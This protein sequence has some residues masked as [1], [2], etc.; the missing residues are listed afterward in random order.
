[1]ATQTVLYNLE[2]GI[3]NTFICS[4]VGGEYAV[5][6]MGVTR[7]KNMA[8]YARYGVRY[9]APLLDLGVHKEE[10]RAL[11]RQH[12]VDPGWGRR[13]SHQGYQPICLLGFQHG[14]DILVDWHTTYPPQR[15]GDYLDEKAE[16]S[17]LLIKA[18]LRARG[19]D[20]ERLI[21][22]NLARYQAEEE[23]IAAVRARTA[24][25]ASPCDGPR[26]ALRGAGAPRP[27]FPF[28]TR[29]SPRTGG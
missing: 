18:A 10:E 19:H 21:A 20:P 14:L 9:N 5:M 27:P 28:R 1:M 6:S 29:G 17:D 7:E 13:R 25:R 22:E 23:A 11:L 4:S 16:V 15:I 2:H 12:G 3:T 26:G 24:A 8:W